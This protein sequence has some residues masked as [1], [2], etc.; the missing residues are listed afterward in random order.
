M[1]TIVLL[2]YKRPDNVR[3][4]IKAL[5]PYHRFLVI[6]NNPKVKYTGIINNDENKFCIERWHKIYKYVTTKYVC[7]LD[8]DIL[9]S[10]NYISKMVEMSDK[11]SR[12]LIGVYGKNGLNS[13]TCYEDLEDSWCEDKEVDLV[14]GACIVTQTK[15]IYDI[16]T[17]YIEPWG[18]RDRGDDL[19]V[20][21]ALTHKYGCK[22]HTVN[23][24]VLMLPEGNEGLNKN[25]LH[26]S[27]RW[28]VIKDFRRQ[29]DN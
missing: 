24:D 17:K 21:Q 14:V 12:S 26:Y 4:I 2:T 27:K 7:I 18:Y 29:Y 11:H 25:P 23:G 16:Y 10:T 22:H 5:K 20:S 1:I 28:E 6:N 13:A 15:N 8:D 19:L 9:P 3:Q